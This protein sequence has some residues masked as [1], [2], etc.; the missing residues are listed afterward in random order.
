MEREV[1]KHC[2]P[3]FKTFHLTTQGM[4]RR[5]TPPLPHTPH[6]KLKRGSYFANNPETAEK[7]NA[8]AIPAALRVAPWL[9]QQQPPS[10][11][12]SAWGQ[13]KR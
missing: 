9:W 1:A 11:L 3:S 12:P 8:C 2:L 7:S 13:H 5:T 4:T 6:H 10:R